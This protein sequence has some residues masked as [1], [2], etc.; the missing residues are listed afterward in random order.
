MNFRIR[1]FAPVVTLVEL[2]GA[3]AAVNAQSFSSSLRV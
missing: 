2:V 1:L 3:P